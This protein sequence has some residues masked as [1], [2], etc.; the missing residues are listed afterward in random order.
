MIVNLFGPYHRLIP[1]FTWVPFLKE[2]ESPLR[3]SLLAGSGDL[4]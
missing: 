4:N 3:R 1:S 2:G